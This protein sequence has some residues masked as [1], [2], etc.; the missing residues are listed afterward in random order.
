[1]WAHYASG[2]G[3]VAL[4][5]ELDPKLHQIEKIEYAGIPD[6]DKETMGKVLN[7]EIHITE[8]G[9]LKRKDSF[10]AYE[11]EWRVFGASSAHYIPGAKPRALIFG[12]RI[13][14]SSVHHAVLKKVSGMSGVRL[15]YLVPGTGVELDVDYEGEGF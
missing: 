14:G 3:G 8:T 2:F 13:S 1:M 6:I 7:R 5:Y 15:G 9:V 4:E 10:W 12:P 11:D